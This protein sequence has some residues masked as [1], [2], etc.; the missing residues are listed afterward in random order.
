M[1]LD[2]NRHV[3]DLLIQ[4]GATALQ[5]CRLDVEEIDNLIAAAEA[6]RRRP[7]DGIRT[8]D[9]HTLIYAQALRLCAK[10]LAVHDNK[11]SARYGRV[12]AVLIDDLR[13]DWS[14]ELDK[15]QRPTA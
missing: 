11:R 8:I 6:L 5:R 1:A 12:V 2:T 13:A 9:D 3:L 14:T 4:R 15:L 10:A 7:A